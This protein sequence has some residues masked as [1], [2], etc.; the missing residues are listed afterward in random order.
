[1]D[2]KYINSK[3]VTLELDKKPYFVEKSGLY[4]FSWSLGFASRPLYD[5]GKVVSRRRPNT[6]RELTLYV[7]ADNETD[8][9]KAMNDIS[10]TLTADV[11]ALSPG[12][13]YIGGQYLSCYVSAG[14]KDISKDWQHCVKITLSFF[15]QN[16]CWCSERTFSFAF[17]TENDEG[18]LKY[19][20][21]Y[22]SRYSSLTRNANIVNDHYAPSPM[23][24]KIFGPAENP[25]FSIGGAAMGVDVTLAQD[26]YA[27]IDQ[28]ERTISKVSAQGEKTNIFNSRLKNGN[29]FSCAPSGVSL[30][31]CTGELN[32][33]VTLIKQRSEPQWS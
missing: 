20:R 23:I 26:E 11:E 1:M 16:P 8:F 22:P 28:I 30:I 10:D 21:K 6:E 27:V 15:P 7:Y 24:I 32:I 31:E 13:L 9:N 29:I 14:E 3:G 2:I 25:R 5:G 19:P 33:S 12:R 17:S 18:G 4:D